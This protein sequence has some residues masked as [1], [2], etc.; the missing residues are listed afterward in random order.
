VEQSDAERQHDGEQNQQSNEGLG[1]RQREHGSGTIRL[2]IRLD[3]FERHRRSASGRVRRDDGPTSRRENGSPH[4][5]REK[6][7][8]SFDSDLDGFRSRWLAKGHSSARGAIIREARLK[9]QK[10]RLVIA[11]VQRFN[12]VK[13]GVSCELTALAPNVG[14]TNAGTRHNETI[15]VRFAR[16]PPSDLRVETRQCPAAGVRIG[17]SGEPRHSPGESINLQFA[18]GVEGP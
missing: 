15:S 8:R 4:S 1:R 14:T 18:L 2:G 13:A 11:G 9:T 12:L 3:A 7:R 5:V 6:T 16:L 10:P 17:P